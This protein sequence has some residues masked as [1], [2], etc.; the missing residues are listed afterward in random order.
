MDHPDKG[1]PVKPCI[2]VFKAKIQS[3]GSLDRLKLIIIVRGDLQNKEIIGYTWYTTASASNLKYL[4]SYDHKEKS[5]VHQ[6]DF[7][8]SFLKAN[9]KN[10]V[11]MKL[12]S[13]HG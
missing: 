1:D 7:I 12:D 3:D 5:R 9:V 6:L 4:L 8:G 13:R 2:D 10:R 11:S